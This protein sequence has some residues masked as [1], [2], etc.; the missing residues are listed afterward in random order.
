MSVG[1]VCVCANFIL[2]YCV[3]VFV[4]PPQHTPACH[5]KI[6]VRPHQ[7]YCAQGLSCSCSAK[8]IFQSLTIGSILLI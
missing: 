3:S 5:L 7:H 4:Q 2:F 6:Y 1:G 8:A